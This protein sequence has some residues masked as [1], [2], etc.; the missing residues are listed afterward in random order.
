MPGVSVKIYLILLCCGRSDLLSLT[1]S[2][3]VQNCKDIRDHEIHVIISDDSGDLDLNSRIEKIS[4]EM[5]S[6]LAKTFTFRSGKNVGQAASYWQCIDLIRKSDAKDQDI[7]FLIEEDWKFLQE[8]KISDLS[9]TLSEKVSNQDIASV[10]LKCD[11]DN[12]HEYKNNGYNLVFHESYFIYVPRSLS[13]LAYTTGECVHNEI[14]CFHPHAILW[15]N[16][17]RYT[18][19]YDHENLIHIRESAEKLLGLI[20]PGMRVFYQDKIY[21]EH[22][23]DYRII[24]V[25]PGAK[26]R[27]GV[28]MISIDEAKRLKA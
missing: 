25:F 13:H 11:V 2:S 26:I 10:T 12:F 7:V 14:I 16:A 6:N 8:F 3:F 1:L 18:E 19:K 20:T 24:S 22:T 5:L 17:K 21:A 15:K 28:T 23:G 4:K 9:K 27:K